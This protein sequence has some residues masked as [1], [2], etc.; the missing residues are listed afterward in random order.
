M[1]ENKK[2]KKDKMIK[3][4][5]RKSK[6]LAMMIFF[7]M[8]ML[9]MLSSVNY[10]NASQYVNI[11]SI[12]GNN[13]ST[14]PIFARGSSVNI[15]VNAS[16]GCVDA[17]CGFT[18]L[19][20]QILRNFNETTFHSVSSITGLTNTTGN[21]STWTFL[22]DTTK[23]TDGTYTLNI[24]MLSNGT[25]TMVVSNLSNVT[26]DNT[27]PVVSTTPS[28]GQAF[29]STTPLIFLT[30]PSILNCTLTVRD[31]G[32]NIKFQVDN[33][34]V[35]ASGGVQTCSALL[36]S[37][38]VPSGNYMLSYL[39]TDGSNVTQG[40]PISFSTG[41]SGSSGGT[42]YIVQTNGNGVIPGSAQPLSVTG[43]QQGTS[44]T[45]TIVVVIIVIVGLF[46]IFS[47][48][49]GKRR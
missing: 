40:G 36:S 3:K 23:T 24:S 27:V 8:I 7:S 11:N 45:G 26:I 20:F 38:N 6:N 47:N 34:S 32:G 21:Q 9:F 46:F 22:W 25:G 30:D 10:V 12:N 31:T 15:S 49:K 42:Q 41:S 18:N 48:K 1:K 43:G 4:T 39:T 2:I 14:Q 28:Q 5:E 44:N 33:T 17:Q 13:E 19:S 37:G 35:V 16:F 29:T